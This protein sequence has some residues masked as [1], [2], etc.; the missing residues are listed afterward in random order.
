ME[1]AVMK[2]AFRGLFVFA[3]PSF[4]LC[5]RGEIT[6]IPEPFP[7]IA[8]HSET[9]TN[10][11][12]R[13]FVAEIDL[14]NPKIHLRVAPGGPDPDG[15][16]KWETTL[17]LPTKIAAREKFEL[18]VNGDFFKA[19]GVN[20]GEGTNAAFRA[21][22]WALTEGPA[23]TDGKTWSTS[24]NARPCFVVRT[25]Q[26]VAFEM[27]ARPAA[28]DWEV[29]G[30][31]VVLVKD[32]VAVPQK[33]KVRHPRTVV[34]LDAAKAK[35][36]LM[37]VDGRKPGIAIGMNYDEIATE[38]LRLGCR[39][40]VNLDGGGSSVMAV[41]DEVTGTMKILNAPT[42]GRERAVADVLGISEEK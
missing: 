20:D 11:P 21:D 32:G 29:V 15:P 1:D 26:A 36:I 22:Q 23:M 40:A 42:D 14:S 30:G 34:G 19:K 17:M 33:N 16:G 38:M 2:F 10:P 37:V 7:G 9:R 25:N 8:L 12:T 13:L 28:E 5:A 24:T 35:L 41:R 39:D 31:N 18:V 4:I 3:L 27:L 6:V